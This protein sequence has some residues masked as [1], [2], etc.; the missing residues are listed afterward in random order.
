M[1]YT[2]HRF[3]SATPRPPRL[4]PLT[5]A[6]HA[7]D[8]QCPDGAWNPLSN[9]QKARL[10]ILARQAAERLGL[11]TRKQDLDAWRHEQSIKACG[12]QISEA[13]QENWADLKSTFEDLAGNPE[14][15]FTTQLRE[16]DNKRR[17][18]M[19]K[20]TEALRKKGLPLSYV[21][22]ICQNQFKC[23]LDQA[24]AKQLW[25]LFF[26]VTNRKKA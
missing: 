24:S 4:Q 23:P 1:K 12:R 6:K 15:A 8:G 7:D 25:C 10:S 18:A 17:V 3:V 9:K 20:L 11:S 21:A 19:H 5:A 2:L 26:T 22:G 16:G 14:K 13:L